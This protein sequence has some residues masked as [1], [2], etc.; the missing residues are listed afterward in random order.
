M[1]TL[2][3]RECLYREI[4]CFQYDTLAF[5]SYLNVENPA[6]FWFNISRETFGGRGVRACACVCACVRSVV[7]T[8]K[9]V[10]GG[11]AVKGMGIVEN[12]LLNKTLLIFSP[13]ILLLVS[14]FLI[15]EFF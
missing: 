10:W 3:S 5:K 8:H 14:M 6:L 13:T 7:H 9:G 4:K 15:T 1:F 11:R 2:Y 12:L